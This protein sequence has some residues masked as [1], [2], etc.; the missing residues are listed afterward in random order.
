M[1]DETK[2]LEQITKARREMQEIGDFATLGFI[3][4]VNGVDKI[5]YHNDYCKGF[6]WAL[7]Y[8]DGLIEVLKGEED[9]S[10]EV[11]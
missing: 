7:H 4:E 9:D 2:L 5:I 6:V 8:V 11:D 3:C 1:I 10:K